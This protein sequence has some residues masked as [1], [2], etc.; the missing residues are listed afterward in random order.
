MSTT[1]IPSSVEAWESRQLGADEQFAEAVENPD[2]EKR[3]ESQLGLKPISIRVPEQLIEDF[4]LIASLNGTIG[5][6]TLMKQCLKRFADSELK[7]IG[8]DL[9]TE[10]QGQG[11]ASRA[12]AKVKPSEPV[13]ELPAAKR[14]KVA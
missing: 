6:Q 13:A 12:A 10:R 14:R 7:R 9:A 3:L 11:V 2:F 4:K 5:Y 8:R 1:K